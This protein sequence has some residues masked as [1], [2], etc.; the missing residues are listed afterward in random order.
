MSTTPNQPSDPSPPDKRPWLKWAGPYVTTLVSAVI[1]DLWSDLRVILEK[2]PGGLF[3]SV[4]AIGLVI[5]LAAAFVLR[6][7]RPSESRPF[8]RM[9]AA[10]PKLGHRLTAPFAGARAVRLRRLV[11]RAWPV[12]T[13]GYLSVVAGMAVV[14]LPWL[15]F[16]GAQSAWHWMNPP[17]CAH[18]ME[19]L[20]MTAP[21]NL[22]ALR[23]RADQYRAETTL[24]GC[25]RYRISVAAAPSIKDMTYGFANGWARNDI[26]QE[27]EP[28]Y[29]LLGQRPDAWIAGNAAEVVRV[30]DVVSK[31]Q[32][33]LQIRANVASDHVAIAVLGSRLDE[34][35]RI[36]P[37]GGP[38]Y[39]L[40]D[41]VAAVRTKL[42]MRLIYPQPGTSSAGLIAAT[43][44]VGLDARQDTIQSVAFDTSVSD[45]LCHFKGRALADRES[46]ALVVPGHSARDYDQRSLVDEGC[47]GAPPS[48][49]EALHEVPVA[50]LPAL[51]Y[52]YVKITWA[53]ARNAARDQAVDAF[54][55]WLRAKRLFA[56]VESA[57]RPSVIRDTELYDAKTLIDSR[58]PSVDLQV[59]FDASKSMSQPPSNLSRVR[60]ALPLIR[61]SLIDRDRISY[62][63]FYDSGG[64]RVSPS[65]ARFVPDDFDD[66]IKDVTRLI[67]QGTDA[68]VSASI[69]EV[70]RRSRS[71]GRTVAVITDGGPLDPRRDSAAAI[72]RAVTGADTVTGLYILAL[73]D[74]G[75]HGLFPAQSRPG[76]DKHVVCRE[77][78]PDV[79]AALTEMISTIRGWS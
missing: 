38:G 9:T 15:A 41:V 42:R 48:G 77:A 11:A 28:F 6:R 55:G 27:N 72:T 29:R 74:G 69:E 49:Q 70:G 14:V 58:L 22:H 18:P 4:P 57:L 3:V 24:D 62:A 63:T 20:V 8:A 47:P 51:D 37:E 36:L 17:P 73:R 33:A 34:L 43:K 76:T 56:P 32:A 10:W 19:L 25:A 12:I 71:I 64:T 35:D 13:I 65:S 30:R 59:L 45:L 68:P 53:G 21:E 67:S 23:E 7:V 52:P 75:C 2:A 61:Q 16:H 79:A 50:G 46:I 31:D 1:T 78:G 66:L 40:D 60:E 26:R 44:L 5:G 54:G 39:A